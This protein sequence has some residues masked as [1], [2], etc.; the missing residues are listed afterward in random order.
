MGDQIH[1]VIPHMPSIPG[2]SEGL[3]ALLQSISDIKEKGATIVPNE[4]M[5]YGAAV[6]IGLKIA[7]TQAIDWAIV[8]NNDTRLLH[9]DLTK[10]HHLHSV[11][12]PAILPSPRDDMPRCF[13]SVCKTVYQQL[14]ERDGFFYDPIFSEDGGYYWEDDDLI[15]RLELYKI[16][17]VHE[18]DVLI[19][20]YNGGG[21]TAKQLGESYWYETNKKKFDIKWKSQSIS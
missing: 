18:P 6:N 4:S 12:T 3:V 11:T 14:L 8:A 5:G 10:L 9:G 21:M 7:F 2:A 1:L 16:P 15:K 20:H 13:F 17:I 19:E